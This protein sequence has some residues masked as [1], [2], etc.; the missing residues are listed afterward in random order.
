MH[1]R[2]V[3]KIYKNLIHFTNFSSE[4]QA[5]NVV[6]CVWELFF[7]SALSEI[8]LAGTFCTWYWT[9]VKDNVPY[10]I[11]AISAARS[12]IYHT[13]TAAFGALLITIC[14][15]LRIITNRHTSGECGLCGLCLRCLFA[16]LT[17][18]LKR[19]NRN[20][21]IMC[22]LHGKGLCASAIDA[23]KLIFRNVLRY[24]AT[25]VVT[26][27]VFVFSKLFLT[28]A[29][30]ALCWIYFSNHYR[31]V[32]VSAVGILIVG[33]YLI[34]SEFFNVY[35]IAVD[36]LMLCAR[37]CN[38]P[39]FVSLRSIPSYISTMKKTVPTVLEKMC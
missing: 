18:F 34:T 16:W 38:I 9:Y 22:A 14:T 2:N 21:Y 27:I 39:I 15:I 12:A 20:A 26:K 23:Y 31:T 6:A 4:F 19:F 10:Y 8:T 33:V 29:A 24:I 1:L 30:G 35:T 28:C 5:F 3:N 11:V 7:I 36:T 17:D 25:D 32:P 13:G 37:K